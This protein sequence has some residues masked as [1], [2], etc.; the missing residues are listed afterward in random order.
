ML[1]LLPAGAI[2]ATLTLGWLHHKFIFIVSLFSWTKPYH[3]TLCFF[4]S[5][6]LPHWSR[7]IFLTGLGRSVWLLWALNDSVW[8]SR[9]QLC[10]PSLCWAMHLYLSP[11]VCVCM[12]VCSCRF[13]QHLSACASLSAEQS[14]LSCLCKTICSH[15]QGIC[16]ID[17]LSQIDRQKERWKNTYFWGVH[18]T[19]NFSLYL[20]YVLKVAWM[21]DEWNLL[22]IMSRWWNFHLKCLN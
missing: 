20:Y 18:K 3:L 9:A 14:T 15:C 8:I 2:E 1:W 21:T 5:I 19:S 7:A 17:Y 4:H 16:I 11:P 10:N 13:L 6:Y 22:K 12:G